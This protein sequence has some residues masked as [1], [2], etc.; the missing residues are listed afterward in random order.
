MRRVV[1]DLRD[2]FR[3]LER[4]MVDVDFKKVE[5]SENCNKKPLW[6][7]KTLG[8]YDSVDTRFVRIYQ[9]TKNGTAFSFAFNSIVDNSNPNWTHN[10]IVTI[11]VQQNGVWFLKD[12]NAY[13][14]RMGLKRLRKEILPGAHTIEIV[15]GYLMH[16]FS[17]KYNADDATF[18]HRER[19]ISDVLT[20]TEFE[21]N[22]VLS[23][24]EVYSEAY[25]ARVKL[26]AKIRDEVNTYQ[27]ELEEKYNLRG[28]TA[29]ESIASDQMLAAS[30]N[31]IA[32]VKTFYKNFDISLVKFV[33]EISANFRDKKDPK[34]TVFANILD[35][36]V[37]NYK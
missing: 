6:C 14:L 32:K 25:N 1:R 33:K 5:F 29:Q 22:T 16:I 3:N 12:I 24:K 31:F 15:I 35:E 19:A 30:A 21:R 28:V 11:I 13:I 27:R 23:S 7:S 26:V 4:A 37:R 10:S 2:T 34:L 17:I 20:G 18:Y 36:S 8:K 9:S